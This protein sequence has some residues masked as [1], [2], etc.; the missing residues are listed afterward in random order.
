M[1]I[2]R[3]NLGYVLAQIRRIAEDIELPTI[4]KKP[5]RVSIATGLHSGA[6]TVVSQDSFTIGSDE[7]SDILLFDDCVVGPA[8]DVRIEQTFFGP[9]V[10]I[11]AD[12]R[13][14]VFV[15][16]NMVEHDAAPE[17]LPCEIKVGLV[18]ISLTVDGAPV[19]AESRAPIKVT[20]LVQVFML[21]AVGAFFS[22]LFFTKSKDSA[23]L[24]VRFNDVPEAEQVDIKYSLGTEFNES[25]LGEYL[26]IDIVDNASAIVSGTLP[27]QRM[28]DWMSFRSRLDGFA[29][30]GA[31]MTNVVEASDINNIPQIAFVDLTGEPSIILSDNRKVNLG[32][33]FV[34][35]WVLESVAAEGI[36]LIRDNE[37]AEVKF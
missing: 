23:N 30:Y 37:K 1:E 13:S 2:I 25:G 7:S 5:I 12:G 32:D 24:L 21:V 10:K 4:E 35:E 36:S 33:V 18:S 14:D 3:R 34:Q 22:V 31:L 27:R 26:E 9:T 16:Q 8:I 20:T 6:E 29:K 17:S 19:V 28:D 11:A 15:N